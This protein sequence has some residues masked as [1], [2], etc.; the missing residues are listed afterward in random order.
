MRI[1]AIILTAAALLPLA[2]CATEFEAYGITPLPLDEGV[3]EAGPRVAVCYNAMVTPKARVAE[4]A[5]QQCAP[6][7]I[8]QPLVTDWHI[9]LC[10]LLL[11]ARANFICAPKA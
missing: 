3:K 5:Q 9:Q 10:P 2:G 11:P 4:L 8:A 6:D 1:I 7:R